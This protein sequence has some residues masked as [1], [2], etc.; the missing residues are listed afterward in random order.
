MKKRVAWS[1]KE[2]SGE[3]KDGVI[4][5]REEEDQIKEEKE[6]VKKEKRRHSGMKHRIHCEVNSIFRI[7]F[8]SYLQGAAQCNPHL[9]PLRHSL[10]QTT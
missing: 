3:G 9:Q 2:W 6:M 5:R 1:R 10:V 7:I 8:C 4:K